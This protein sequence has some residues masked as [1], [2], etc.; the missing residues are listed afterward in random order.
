MTGKCECDIRDCGL[1]DT[2][3]LLLLACRLS[4][5]YD[6]SWLGQILHAC[7]KLNATVD[8]HLPSS[9]V[10]PVPLPWLQVKRALKAAYVDQVQ[11]LSEGL[12]P[13]DPLCVHRKHAVLSTWFHP[14]HETW[15]KMKGVHTMWQLPYMHHKHVA[16]WFCGVAPVATAH[17]KFFVNCLPEQILLFVWSK[18]YWLRTTCLTTLRRSAAHQVL[19]SYFAVSSSLTWRLYCST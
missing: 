6:H 1:E 5:E 11:H 17:Y 3:V 12:Q 7:A 15:F 18:C 10:Q 19:V 13:D 16:K 8:S 9:M 2:F 14:C 4:N